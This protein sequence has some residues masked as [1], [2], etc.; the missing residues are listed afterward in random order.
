MTL[1]DWDPSFSVNISQFDS[2]HKD[3]IRLLNEAHENFVAKARQEATRIV[4]DRL[5]DYAQY[6]F[7]AEEKWMKIQN[8]P[9]LIWHTAEHNAFWR[10]IFD[11]QAD[12]N[13]G[14]KQ[15]SAEV[16]TYLRDWFENHVLTSDA[17]YGRFAASLLEISA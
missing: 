12:Y 2:H 9:E 16:L 1:I 14:E 5:V 10:Q 4:I 6:H 8:Y 7:S 17:D 11:F 15:L 13:N 3:L